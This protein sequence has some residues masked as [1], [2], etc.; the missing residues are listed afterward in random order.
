MTISTVWSALLLTD[1]EVDSFSTQNLSELIQSVGFEALMY[2]SQFEGNG[3]NVAIF[4]IDDVEIIN[5][6]PR[7][8]TEMNV[9]SR[10]I[11]NH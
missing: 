1:R 2:R 10:V 6:A 11:G 5:C 4:N 9:Q 7:E 3:L 8:V